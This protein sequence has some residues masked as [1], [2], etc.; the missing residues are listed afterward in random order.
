[1]HQEDCGAEE[2]STKSHR[3]GIDLE[4]EPLNRPFEGSRDADVAHDENEFHN[5]VLEQTHNLIL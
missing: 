1:M 3:T 5:P 4:F 2:L